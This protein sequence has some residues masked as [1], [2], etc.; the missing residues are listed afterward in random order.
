M[1][2]L[3]KLAGKFL[4]DIYFSKDLLKGWNQALA[5]SRQGDPREP[6]TQRPLQTLV[7]KWFNG[8][9]STKGPNKGIRVVLRK[10]LEKIQEKRVEETVL[11]VS[12]GS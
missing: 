2:S 8:Y 10:R 11:I 6:H 3:V 9:K 1:Y 4:R 12:K 7:V 5:L